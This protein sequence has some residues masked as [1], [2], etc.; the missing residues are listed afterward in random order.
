MPKIAICLTT[1]LREKLLYYACDSIINYLPEDIIL[2]IAD[3]SK[4]SEE[5]ELKINEIKLKIPCEYYRLPFDCG[6]SYARN[7]LVQKAN[8]MNIPYCL[9]MADSNQFTQLYDFQLIID[10]LEENP[11]RGIVGFDLD[12]SKCEWEYLMEVTPIGLKFSYPTEELIF[13]DIKFTKVDIC[14]NIFLAKTHTLLDLWDNEQ[15]LCEHEL[16]FLEYKKRGYEVHWTNHIQL[17]RYA[18]TSEEYT[19]FRKRW[20]EYKDTAK[21][22]LGIPGWIILPKR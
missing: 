14:R 16:A 4:I 2:L 5:K 11:K 3:Q 18:R 19:Y 9:I 12:K 21:R 20:K 10:F 8:E 13:K 6:L 22:K 1:F 15:K 7:F 17:L